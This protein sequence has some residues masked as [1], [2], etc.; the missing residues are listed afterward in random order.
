MFIQDLKIEFIKT[1]DPYGLQQ[2]YNINPAGQGIKLVTVVS[3]LSLRNYD[4]LTTRY[5]ETAL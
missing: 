4:V 3:G 1:Y 5:R 2:T